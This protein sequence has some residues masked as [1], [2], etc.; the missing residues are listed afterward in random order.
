MARVGEAEAPREGT[1]RAV[2]PL[3]PPTRWVVAMHH[4]DGT[5]LQMV[6]LASRLEAYRMRRDAEANGYL[7]TIHEQ[8]GVARARE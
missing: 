4:P 1:R 3:H 7:V 6:P 2:K 8:P 5:L